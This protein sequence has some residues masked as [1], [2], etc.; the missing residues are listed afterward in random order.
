MTTNVRKPF[1]LFPNSPDDIVLACYFGQPTPAKEL[2]AAYRALKITT[3]ESDFSRLQAAVASVVLRCVQRQL[4]QWAVVQ[5]GQVT[6][7]RQVKQRR[8][9]SQFKPQHLFTLNWADTAPGFSWPCAYYATRVPAHA[10][11]VVTASADCPET[12]GWCDIAIGHFP[13]VDDIREGARRVITEH[14]K[15]LAGN[16]QERWAYLFAEGLVDSEMA[17]AWADR[18]WPAD[19]DEDEEQDD[20]EASL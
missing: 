6:R 8:M 3:A 5:D 16:D 2:S 4:P 19:A 18:V 14:W 12:F 15:F 11:I 7:A 9:K 17:D 1:A 13:A 10:G 20:E